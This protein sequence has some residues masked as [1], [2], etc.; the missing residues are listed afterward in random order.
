MVQVNG[1]MVWSYE[2][3]YGFPFVGL[4]QQKMKIKAMATELNG[5]AIDPRNNHAIN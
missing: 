5:L 4:D 2:G 3:F 1:V